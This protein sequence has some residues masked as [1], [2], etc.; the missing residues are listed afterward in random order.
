MFRLVMG[1]V[2]GEHQLSVKHRGLIK[3]LYFEL[4]LRFLA[5][6]L[7]SSL[8]AGHRTAPLGNIALQMSS[9]ECLEKV[10]NIGLNYFMVW[11]RLLC[12]SEALGTEGSGCC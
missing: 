9:F 2:T 4:F 10:L 6:L 3:Q 5:R 11:F 8:W 1:G 7:R 12:H